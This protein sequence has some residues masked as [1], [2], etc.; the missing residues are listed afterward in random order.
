MW[1]GRVIYHSYIYTAFRND[2]YHLIKFLL[3]VFIYLLIFCVTVLERIALRGLLV[4]PEIHGAY[5]Q[6]MGGGLA[7]FSSKVKIKK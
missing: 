4:I 2:A 5:H 3:R 7:H 1:L 6:Y